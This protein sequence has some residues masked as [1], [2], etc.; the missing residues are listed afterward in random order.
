MDISKFDHIKYVNIS[1]QLPYNVAT[2]RNWPWFAPVEYV[3]LIQKILSGNV[4]DLDVR[5]DLDTQ[6]DMDLRI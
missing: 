3:R 1:G 4:T 6:T 2:V 5:T